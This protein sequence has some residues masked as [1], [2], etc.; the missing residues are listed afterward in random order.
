ML[1]TGI[2]LTGFLMY[3]IMLQVHGRQMRTYL[4]NF[5]GGTRLAVSGFLSPGSHVHQQDEPWHPYLLRFGLH[6]MPKPASGHRVHQY[7]ALAAYLGI[8][9]G[10]V[11]FEVPIEA[12]HI[13]DAERVIEDYGLRDREIIGVMR[14][15]SRPMR[16][17]KKESFYS[18][19]DSIVGD[20]GHDVVVFGA[21]PEGNLNSR[22]VVD[23]RGKTSFPIDVYLTRYSGVC[24]VIVGPDTGMMHIAGSVSSNQDGTYDEKTQ[25]NRTVS[26]FGPT[27]YATYG[28]Y[29]PTRRF[30][31][32][33]Q[34][35]LG[36]VKMS[37][38]GVPD[39]DRKDYMAM[40]KSGMVIEKVE[41]HLK[42][43][44]VR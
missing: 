1:I 33:V 9:I 37:F 32:A 40:V 28:P 20:L 26:I 16:D 39:F 25:G 21:E 14:R 44:A 8:P 35:D 17:W 23:L 22:H 42:K 18:T 12:R 7:M 15:T 3:G 30:N 11:S 31:L 10:R 4:Q 19:I 2:E 6:R 13:E 24:K 27:N 36:N 34:P 43:M 29:D 41:R 38:W 5:F